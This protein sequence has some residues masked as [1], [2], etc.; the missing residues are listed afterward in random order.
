MY[1]PLKLLPQATFFQLCELLL[2]SL[3]CRRI[4]R[5]KLRKQGLLSGHIAR[6]PESISH[7]VTD[8]SERSRI[9][10]VSNSR[11]AASRQPVTS[12]RVGEEGAARPKGDSLK[13]EWSFM[14]QLSYDQFQHNKVKEYGLTDL[15]FSIAP[16]TVRHHIRVFNK[17]YF[18]QN[19]FC[20]SPLTMQRRTYGRHVATHHC[21]RNVGRQSICGHTRRRLKH[22]FCN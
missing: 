13:T 18:L 19:S 7:N 16:H 6:K 3:L 15:S 4:G 14:K 10:A 2:A 1:R 11:R 22:L 12:T 8:K 17:G 21:V 5:R 9:H 20:G